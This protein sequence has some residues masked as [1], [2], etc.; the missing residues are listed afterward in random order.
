MGNQAGEQKKLVVYYNDEEDSEQL[1]SEVNVRNISD[2]KEKLLELTGVKNMNGKEL[3]IV[4]NHV[5]LLVDIQKI[6]DGHEYNVVKKVKPSICKIYI[7][8]K[9]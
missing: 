2:L 5:E 7:D 3:K 1:P 4:F 9:F 8:E 6:I